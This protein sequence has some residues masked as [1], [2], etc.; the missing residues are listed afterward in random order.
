ML[1]QCVLCRSD[2]RCF[3]RVFRQYRECGFVSVDYAVSGVEFCVSV[4]DCSGYEFRWIVLHEATVDV[5]S[6]AF[7]LLKGLAVPDGI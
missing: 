2:V 4:D 7:E 6:D 1:L 3:V 5:G